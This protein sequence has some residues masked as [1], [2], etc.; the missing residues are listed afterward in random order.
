MFYISILL[1]T[2]ASIQMRTIYDRLEEPGI[3]DALHEDKH[4]GEEDQSKP[5]NL[6][7]DAKS[8][9]AQKNHRERGNKRN[10]SQLEVNLKT[11][12]HRGDLSHYHSK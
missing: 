9:W 2:L 10:V 1:I 12:K 7:D 8:L 5:V 3:P 11:Q 4:G 6:P